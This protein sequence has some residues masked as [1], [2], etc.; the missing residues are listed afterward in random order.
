MKSI[1]SFIGSQWSSFRTGVMCWRL[2]VKVIARARVLDNLKFVEVVIRNA[3][4][5]RVAI[6]QFAR[7]KRE[8]ARRVAVDKERRW[9]MRLRSQMW[10]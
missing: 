9:R 7:D 5:E 6:V 3:S 2:E 8:L 4:V 10:K 1:R